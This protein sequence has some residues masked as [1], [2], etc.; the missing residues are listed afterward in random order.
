[1]QDV[2]ILRNFV[3]GCLDWIGLEAEPQHYNI[4]YLPLTAHFAKPQMLPAS[5]STVVIA[6]TYNVW[7]LIRLPV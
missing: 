7:L 2:V 6:F 5:L 1:M 4:I 3:N